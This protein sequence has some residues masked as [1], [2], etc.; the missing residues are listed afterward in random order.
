M[1]ARFVM[2]AELKDL[3]IANY[4]MMQEIR[5]AHQRPA[6]VSFQSNRD[7]QYEFNALKSKTTIG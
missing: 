5:D 2:L 7:R 6:M 4:R 3:L 1:G